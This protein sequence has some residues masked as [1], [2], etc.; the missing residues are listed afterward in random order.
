[1]VKRKTYRTIFFLILVVSRM[2]VVQAS[3]TTKV[4]K[5]RLYMVAG[6]TTLTLAGTYYYLQNVWWNEDKTSFK[7]DWDM[8]YR[9]ARNL[10]KT[11]H[12]FGGMITAELFDAAFIWAGVPKKRSIWYAAAAGNVIQTFIELKDAFAPTYGFSLGDWGAGTLGSCIPLLQHYY[13]KTKAIT[14]K[15]SYYRHH[16]YYY[17]QFPYAQLID[18][19]MNQTYWLSVS[20]ND[21]L[22]KGSRIEKIWPDF[23][24][25]AGGWGTDET[26]NYYYKGVNLEENK[27]KGREEFYLSIDVDWRKIIKQR[28][29]FNR[30]LS[31]SLN[32]I[33]LPM[34]T[35]RFAPGT[36]W[37]PFYL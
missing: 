3:D 9:Y 11:G 16:D 19:Y 26:L 1:M 28:T 30:V 6:A 27:G 35:V 20:V 5:T 4:N 14:F 15:M 2:C 17:Q 24:T 7:I 12:F 29:T 34:P 10:D 25:I 22:P 18:D 37:Y 33:K 23:L 13:P 32:C 31:Y 8:D 36:K 21:W